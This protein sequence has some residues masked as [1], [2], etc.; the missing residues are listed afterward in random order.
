LKC[1]LCNR[2]IRRPWKT[3]SG[4]MSKPE[5]DGYHL[6]CYAIHQAETSYDNLE[7]RIKIALEKDKK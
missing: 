6:R 5:R 7:Q 3:V 2:N 1:K 4:G